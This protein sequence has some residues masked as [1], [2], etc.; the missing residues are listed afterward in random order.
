MGRMGAKGIKSDLFSCTLMPP[1]CWEGKVGTRRKREFHLLLA[2][3][4]FG[5]KEGRL[6]EYWRSIKGTKMGMT[7]T[8]LHGSNFALT[9]WRKY[10]SFFSYQVFQCILLSWTAAGI[11]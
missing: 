6:L 1:F 4:I 10:L 2:T 8:F 5:N 7:G 3:L 11:F 9:H